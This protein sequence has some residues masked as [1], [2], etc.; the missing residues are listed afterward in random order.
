MTLK[1]K[2]IGMVL[3]LIGLLGAVSTFGIL[4]LRS[5]GREIEEIAEQD[6]PLTEIITKITVNQ[7]ERPASTIRRHHVG[8]ACLAAG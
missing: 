3:I 2:I 8:V 6:I 5:I 7:L 1:A 4:K